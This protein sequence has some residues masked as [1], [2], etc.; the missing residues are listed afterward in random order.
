[1]TKP[2]ESGGHTGSTSMGN[3]SEA[4]IWGGGQA[5]CLNAKDLDGA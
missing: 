1:M 2:F 4:V 5:D 3:D